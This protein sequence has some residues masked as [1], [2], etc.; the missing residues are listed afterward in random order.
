M[1]YVLVL[2]A[3]VSYGEAIATVPGYRTRELCEEAGKQYAPDP[4]NGWQT[5]DYRFKCIAG[6]ERQS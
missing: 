3:H 5:P 4:G 6:P 1:T 2:F